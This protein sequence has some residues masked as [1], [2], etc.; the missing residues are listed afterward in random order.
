[1]LT[2]SMN[3][4]N[5]KSLLSDMQT[6]MSTSWSKQEL[7]TINQFVEFLTTTQIIQTDDL[8]FTERM[9]MLNALRFVDYD[10]DNL[11]IPLE[12]LS[13]L[14][15][16]NDT[17]DDDLLYE[18]SHI[19]RDS[20]SENEDRIYVTKIVRM[21]G[22]VLDADDLMQYDIGL[23]DIVHYSA[24]INFETIESIN[25]PNQ[26]MYSTDSLQGFFA[27]CDSLVEINISG[28]SSKELTDMSNMFQQC[29]RLR[30]ANISNM[31]VPNVKNMSR[32]FEGCG[33]LDCV[34]MTNIFAQRG[35]NTTDMFK[36]TNPNISID[37][38]FSNIRCT[39]ESS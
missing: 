28:L 24:Y 22:N 38:S 16:D 4:D 36:F 5:D 8:N 29:H 35:C 13:S 30:Y 21:M 37:T 23:D 1:M 14:L 31:R 32:M 33:V 7:R 39:A 6:D 10:Y 9:N 34:N 20:L 27:Y 25:M 19:N 17:Y 11:N 18:C 15:T 2:T 12:T 26:S 3:Q